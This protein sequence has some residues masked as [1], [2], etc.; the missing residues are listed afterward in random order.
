MENSID[1]NKENAQD[2]QQSLFEQYQAQK[3][4]FEQ[5][6]HSDLAQMP[7][8]QTN[9]LHGGNQI[10]ALSPVLG[11][12]QQSTV[13]YSHGMNAVNQNHAGSRQPSIPAP[14]FNS[15]LTQDVN[16]NDDVDGDLLMEFDADDDSHNISILSKLSQLWT[17]E[18][19]SPG[20]LQFDQDTVQ[21]AIELMEAQSEIIHDS[22]LELL[23]RGEI[24][25]IIGVELMEF[26]LERV[27]YTLKQYLLSR[28]QKI[29]D[30]AWWIVAEEN[31]EQNVLQRLS[32]SEQ[33]FVLYYSQLTARHYSSALSQ[34]PDKHQ[35]LASDQ[36]VSEP[37]LDAPV[38]VRVKKDLGVV[39]LFEN[40]QLEMKINEIYFIRFRYIEELLH[41][42]VVD[43]L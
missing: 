37:P 27:R 30:N 40:V 38:L 42:N 5:L 36:M 39:Q 18:Q 29:Q 6:V 19:C 12:H 10:T 43:I 9:S 11:Q 7:G 3:A 21:D 17:R 2:D 26:E 22:R 31:N 28:I 15:T 14:S 32:H 35:E 41:R 4:Q 8:M 24:D 13:Q 16:G 25:Q 20:I 34:L 33:E 23:Q 1:N